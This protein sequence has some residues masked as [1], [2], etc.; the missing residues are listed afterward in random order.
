MG[1]GNVDFTG[2]VIYNA[3]VLQDGQ[4]LIGSA[5]APNIRVGKLAS[6]DGSITITNG[7][8]T[9][10][11]SAS[12]VTS[13]T[14]VQYKI[15]TDGGNFFSTATTY[16][17]G[18]VL[19]S[20]TDGAAL[21]SGS[22]TPLNASNL[23]VVR[24]QTASFIDVAAFNIQASWLLRDSGTSAVAV[25]AVG[26]DLGDVCQHNIVYQTTAGSTAATTFYVRV[27]VQTAGGG[28]LNINGW[29]GGGTLGG[30]AFSTLEILE[31]T[32]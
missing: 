21:M 10:D 1:A 17:A 2:N 19:P 12:A 11:L 4:L 31:I 13:G 25:R 23:L 18:N 30:G 5:V 16:G 15:Y 7:H 8:G 32:P 24:F 9:I 29:F 3:T 27:G 20:N 14:L 6:A 22:I 26:A 28:T